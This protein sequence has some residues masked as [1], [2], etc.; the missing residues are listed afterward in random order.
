MQQPSLTDKQ[1]RFVAEYLI[2]L[3]ATQAATRAGYSRKTANEQGARLLAKVSVRYAIEEA[4]KAREKRTNITQD[5]VLQEL[6]RIAFFDIRKLY[7][8]DGSMKAPHELDDDAA[9]VLAGIDVIEQQTVD[10]DGEGNVTRSPTLTKKAKVFDKGGALTLAMR[11]LGML[12]DKTEL[13]GKDGA[14]LAPPVLNIIIGDEAQDA[15]AA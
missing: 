4:M 7:R 14:P 1:Q 11:H 13:T 12:T 3:N 10:V 5:R 2:D 9:A 15:A 8:E 6:S